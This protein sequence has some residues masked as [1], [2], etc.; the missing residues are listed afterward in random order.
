MAPEG[1]G[2]P[3][4]SSP[5]RS[6]LPRACPS[7]YKTA[8]PNSLN[9]DEPQVTSAPVV[10]PPAGNP[11]SAPAAA[12]EPEAAAAPRGGGRVAAPAGKRPRASRPDQGVAA[13]KAKAKAP[14]RDAPAPPAAAPP[15]GDDAKEA[16]EEIKAAR[17][18]LDAGLALVTGSTPVIDLQGGTPPPVPPDGGQPPV[19]LSPPAVPDPV[20]SP[21]R[22]STG[23]MVKF[24]T[25]RPRAP[26]TAPGLGGGLTHA[27]TA[28]DQ[29]DE[30]GM[31]PG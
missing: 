28:P 12:A 20:G 3:A 6:S 30:A 1:G 11:P 18:G 29:V 19:E 15:G 31:E 5:S 10:N 22:P 2:S 23:K 16:D 21:G 17:A 24:R 4:K 7:R 9:L 13:P 27:R 26:A 25:V 8:F 14:R